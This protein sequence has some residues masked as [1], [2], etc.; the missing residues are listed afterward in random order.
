MGFLENVSLLEIV[1]RHVPDAELIES[2]DFQ[3]SC[4]CYSEYT[5]EPCRIV[6]E[7]RSDMVKTYP[8]DIDHDVEEYVRRHATFSGCSCCSGY[9]HE[10]EGSEV[11]YDRSNAALSVFVRILPK[12]EKP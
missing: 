12:T 6:I 5:T 1:K 4:G 11:I 8:T 10:N 3:D 9:G 7:V 2:V